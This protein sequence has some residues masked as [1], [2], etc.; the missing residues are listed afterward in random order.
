MT[1]VFKRWPVGLFE[2]VKFPLPYDVI[3]RF[4]EG[5]HNDS[6]VVGE[7]GDGGDVFDKGGICNKYQ[8]K[9]VVLTGGFFL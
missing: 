1:P 8:V 6:I 9:N 3:A 4:N 2:I 7:A 5:V